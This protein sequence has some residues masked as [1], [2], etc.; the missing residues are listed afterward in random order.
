MAKKTLLQMVQNILSAMDS[1][2]VNSI[3][4]TVESMQVAEIVRETFEELLTT[5]SIP[6]R[7]GL[8]HLESLG[9]TDRPNYLKIP[10]SV[11][12][13][14][15]LRYNDREIMYIT[16]EEFIQYVID[17]S[18]NVEVEDFQKVKYFIESDRDPK[19]WTC[20]DDKY[21]VFSSFN[22]DAESTLQESNSLAYASINSPF[23]LED[24]Y[25]PNI[26]DNL[27]PL[28]LA[29]AKSACFINLKQVSNANEERRARRQLVRAQNELSR[30]TTGR[31]A[32]RLPHYGRRR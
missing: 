2:E 22:R 23:Y 5:L 12:S 30:T 9:D 24:D 19:Y 28:L 8:V 17:T 14:L 7:R 31:P 15:W 26:D 27:F 29:E 32:D 1:D 16:P 10:D 4:D 6:E 21:L 13:V 20:F 11:K 18:G 3:S 25:I